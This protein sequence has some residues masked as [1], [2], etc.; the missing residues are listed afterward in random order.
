[1][2]LSLEQAESKNLKSKT[3]RLKTFLIQHDVTKENYTWLYVAGHTQ[4]AGTLRLL[5]RMTFNLGV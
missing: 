3:L 2:M 4:K 1:M 5:L